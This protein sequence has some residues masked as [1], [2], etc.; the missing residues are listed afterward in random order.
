MIVCKKML[1]VDDEEP[2]REILKFIFKDDF[3]LMLV[4]SGEA[5]LEAIPEFI[6]DIT[7]LDVMMGGIDGYETCRQIRS[8]PDSASMIVI[9]ISAR[10]LETD[11]QKGFDAGANLYITKPFSLEEIKMKVTEILTQKT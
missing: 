10:A 3:Q 4:E 5:A 2:N 11:I 7:L 9:M 8:N 1:I 6:P